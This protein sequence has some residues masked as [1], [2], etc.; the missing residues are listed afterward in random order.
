MCGIIDHRSYMCKFGFL[1]DLMSCSGLVDRFQ[2]SHHYHRISEKINT[3]IIF[4]AFLFIV[5]TSLLS[6]DF[7]NPPKI[8]IYTIGE[9]VNEK[10]SVSHS[11]TL[12]FWNWKTTHNETTTRRRGGN[13]RS[14]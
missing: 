13:V 5:R 14:E 6:A 2:F 9:P 10:I 12:L 8:I 11:D 4:S 7:K 3:R 1:L